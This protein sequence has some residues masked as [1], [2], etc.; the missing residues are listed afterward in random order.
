MFIDKILS[1]LSP[2]S[3]K[4]YRSDIHGILRTELIDGKK[5]LSTQKG[6]Y[7]YGS[8]QRILHKGLTEVGLDSSVKS[9]LVLG[10]GGG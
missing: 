8:L 3:L 7:S 1:Y 6:N 5:V 2:I 9:I 10:L 4:K